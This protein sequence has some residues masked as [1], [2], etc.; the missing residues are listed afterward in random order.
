MK[1]ITVSVTDKTYAEGRKWAAEHGTSIS[2]AVEI[3]IAKLPATTSNENTGMVINRVRHQARVKDRAAR[4]H[5]A[6]EISH[7]AAARKASDSAPQPSTI[8]RIF[9][10]LLKKHAE[11]VQPQAVPIKSTS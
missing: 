8:F 2:A 4:M 11:T 3:L 7:K 6:P 1:N 9:S 10:N 5:A